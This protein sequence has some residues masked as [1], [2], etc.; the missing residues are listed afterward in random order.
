MIPPNVADAIHTV[1]AA[2][3][4]TPQGE[5]AVGAAELVDEWLERTAI[6]EAA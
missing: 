1:L 2:F 4:K 5:D 6:E 3:Y